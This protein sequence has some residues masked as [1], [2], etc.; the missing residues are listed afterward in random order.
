MLSDETRQLVNDLYELAG[1]N[2]WFGRTGRDEDICSLL[3]KLAKTSESGALPCVIQFLFSSSVN[4]RMAAQTVVASLLVQISP[5]DLLRLESLS[6][7]EWHYYWTQWR[8]ISPSEIR[9]LA[10]DDQNQ[11]QSSIL[12]FASF[13]RNGFVRHEAVR[14]LANVNDGTELSFLLIRQNDWV[15]PIAADAQAA[16]DLRITDAYLP[17]LVKSL[18]LILHLQKLS[19]RDH[20]TIVRRTVELLL[21]NER[22]EV[23]H[24]AVESSIDEVRREIVRVGLQSDGENRIG[25]LRHGLDS[26]DPLIRL[27]CCRYLPRFFDSDALDSKLEKLVTDSFMPLRREVMRIR[28]GHFPLQTIGVWRK[29]L[30][31]PHRS[32]R[33]EA[34]FYLRK[35]GDPNQAEFYRQAILDRPNSLASIEGLAETG[36][37][38]DIPFFQNLLNHEFPNRRC[39]AIRGISRIEGENAISDFLPLLR[40]ESP[41][42]IREA[43]KALMPHLY[44]VGGERLFA[45]ALEARFHFARHMAINLIAEMGKWASIPWLIR[46]ASEA[47]SETASTA[48]QKIEEWFS[49][50]KSNRVF[51]RPSES[52][53][54]SIK[55]AVLSSDRL[56]Q[57]ISDLINREI[58]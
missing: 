55:E 5:Y 1:K 2:S 41:N 37:A 16:I 39:A 21:T 3:F 40:D 44:L 22:E 17:H 11:L 53:R 33:E 57:R 28:A 24:A 31:D 10:T 27:A 49:P 14:L 32:I 15:H 56:S 13:H 48:E 43:A 4:V 46:A 8:E 26:N 19:R 38:S 50:P 42:V 23:L 25:L 6:W 47:N 12:G 36:D 30:L 51:T 7:D 58:T 34:R 9:R 54:Q 45:I 20:S 18:R 29:A 35:L 52:Q